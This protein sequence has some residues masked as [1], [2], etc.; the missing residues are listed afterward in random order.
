MRPLVPK[1]LLKCVRQY[2]RQ[3]V[4]SILLCVLCVW[5]FSNY[6]F[7]DDRLKSKEQMKSTNDLSFRL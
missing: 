3:F 5:I 1:R 2:A 4:H 6:E 7:E